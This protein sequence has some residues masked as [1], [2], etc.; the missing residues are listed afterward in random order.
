MAARS[1]LFSSVR[2]VFSS[3]VW[4]PLTAWALAGACVHHANPTSPPV[5]LPAAY[6]TASGERDASLRW[7]EDIGDP[8]LNAFLDEALRG[9]LDLARARA[10]LDQAEAAASAAGVERLPQL[11]IEGG[12]RRART[13]AMVGPNAGD[14]IHTDTFSLGLAAAYEFDLWDRVGSTARAAQHEAEASRDDFATARLTLSGEI[15]DIWLQAR[16]Q[17]AQL[18]LLETQRLAAHNVLELT[19]QRFAEG[20]AAALDV[21]QQRQQLATIEALI[22]PI[23]AR[24]RVLRHQL[25]VLAGRAPSAAPAPSAGLPK[26]PPLPAAGLPGDLLQR[27]PDVRAALARLAAAD[28]R[29]GAA[30]AARLPTI[31][32]SA[33]AG[34]QASEASVLFN[35]WIGAFAGHAA[36]PLIDGGRRTA[37]TRRARA[38]AREAMA[39]AGQTILKAMREVEDALAQEERQREAIRRLAAQAELA[40][41]T[42]TQARERYAAGLSD[43]LTVLTALDRLQGVER[44][45]L[46]ARRQAWQYRIQLYR[47]LGGEPLAPGAKKGEP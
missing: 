16:E 31:R 33:N 29:I 24:Y 37:E 19:E 36:M 45:L 11:T 44:N 13:L 34:Y 20:H 12:A 22:P 9:S 27:R 43:Y 40:A 10:R 1:L 4:V 28:E 30:I 23:E 2:Y 42:L 7:W 39:V 14:L 26:L 21:L 25:A 6:V 46:A 41:E 15:A 5:V 17:A 32:L 18:A 47:A 8:E 35:E 38:A 3:R